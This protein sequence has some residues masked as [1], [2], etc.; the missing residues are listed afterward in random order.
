MAVGRDTPQ[1]MLA[2]I[3]Q[4]AVEVVPDV[5]MRHRE[6]RSLHQRLECRFGQRDALDQLDVVD[7]GEFRRRQC[8]QRE[9]AS[10]RADDRALAGLLELDRH[11]IRQRA[12]DVEQLARRHGHFAG[13][14]PLRFRARHHLDFEIG[15]GERDTVRIDVDQEIRQH[16]Q[17]LPPLDDTDD[18]L[19]APQEGFSLDAESHV[20][21]ILS[22]VISSEAIL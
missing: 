13:V 10:S 8:R 14:E 6:A 5:L 15:S 3:E 1:R 20:A 16:G 21:L 12:A 7:D 4:H 18:L 22:L 9:A 11:A 19:Q 17:R 2:Q